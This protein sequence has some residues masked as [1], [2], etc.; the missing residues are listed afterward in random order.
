MCTAVRRIS[1]SREDHCEV[2]RYDVPTG[3]KVWREAGMTGAAGG[4]G[5][6]GRDGVRGHAR[7]N[8]PN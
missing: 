6:V 3:P 5:G 7:E 1:C 8:T 2:L 4:Q